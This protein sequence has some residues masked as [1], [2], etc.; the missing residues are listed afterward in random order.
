MEDL[1]S[2][3]TVV[4]IDLCTFRHK[5]EPVC[6]AFFLQK[7]KCHIHI[8]HHRKSI[9]Q[10]ACSYCR[11]TAGEMRIYDEDIHGFEASLQLFAFSPAL[12]PQIAAVMTLGILRVGKSDGFH[13]AHNEK[14]A[15][16]G[17]Y[18]CTGRRGQSERTD[19]F[20]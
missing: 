5:V 16:D 13:H 18:R 6:N 20:G 3:E 12:R 19:L 2:A 14:I 9:S 10:T 7:E 11:S 17:H 1:I 4:Q 15:H 8:R